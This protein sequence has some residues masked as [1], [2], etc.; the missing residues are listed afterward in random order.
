MLR[1][2][3]SHVPS[4]PPP[5]EPEAERPDPNSGRALSETLI[6]ARRTL[7]AVCAASIA[8]SAAQFNVSEVNLDSIGITVSLENASISLLLGAAVLYLTCRWMIEFAMM[9]RNVRRWPLARLDFRLVLLLV[10]FAVLAL[11]AG[12]LHRSLWTVSL[13]VGAV[14]TLALLSS[15]LTGALVFFTMPVRMWARRRANAESA[16]NAAMEA[17][18]WAVIFAA[19]LTVSG[20]IAFA[21]A[22]FRYEPLRAWLWPV[23]PDPVAFAVFMLTLNVAFLSH[24]FLRPVMSSLFAER[25]SYR[26]HRDSEGRLVYQFGHEEREPLL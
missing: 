11:A 26:T 24:W 20:T 6:A 13:V 16:A 25:P 8:W 12:A 4:G 15:L 7:V 19:A 21:I 3:F 23:P 17:F 1:E 2:F 10:R 14:L 18:V 5:E 9:P 22:S